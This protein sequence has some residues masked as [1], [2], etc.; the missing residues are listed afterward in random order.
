MAYLLTSIWMRIGNSNGFFTPPRRPRPLSPAPPPP[1]LLRAASRPARRAACSPA[2]HGG[3][4]LGGCRPPSIAL[5]TMCCCISFILPVRLVHPLPLFLPRRLLQLPCQPR[6]P[7]R[8][9]RVGAP[10]GGVLRPRTPS[11]VTICR[12]LSPPIVTVC[13]GG[14]WSRPPHSPSPAAPGVISH[15][16]AGGPRA[17]SSVGTKSAF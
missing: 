8:A 9:W 10:T 4:G 1:R 17:G 14:P 11:A 12:Q 6:D 16:M 13:R 15:L 5:I 3:A 2:A 7:C